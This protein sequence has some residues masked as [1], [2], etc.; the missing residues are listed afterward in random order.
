[1]A[2]LV[3][4][5]L[6]FRFPFRGIKTFKILCESAPLCAADDQ[7]MNITQIIF[8]AILE[9][10]YESRVTGKEITRVPISRF[11]TR[12]RLENVALLSRGTMRLIFNM[13]AAWSPL[14]I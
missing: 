14:T 12:S 3:N 4:S 2:T 13:P 10:S 5:D 6:P 9:S 7:K 11:P 1:M 8:R